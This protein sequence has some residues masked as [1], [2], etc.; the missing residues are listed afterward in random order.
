MGV[1]GRSGIGPQGYD[2]LQLLKSLI[3]QAWHGLSDPGLE[4]ARRVRLDFM[5]L[6]GLDR[7]VPDETTFCG[8]RGLLTQRGIWQKI[9]REINHQLE[10][11]GVQV[12]PSKGAVLDAT[13][14]ASA[15]RP[16]K[17]LEGMVVDR[18]EDNVRE[19]RVGGEVSLSADP[20]A[21]WLKKGKK[22]YFG[23]KGFVVTDSVDGAIHEVH[24][25][26]AHV[27]EVRTMEASMEAL[28]GDRK[29]HRLYG[30]KGYAS[31]ENR[32]VLKAK[33][34]RDGI[35]HKAHKNKP[36]THWQKLA[37][38]LMSKTR[39]IV[40]QAFGTLKRRFGFVRASYM[41]R[42][43]VEAQLIAKAIAFNLLKASR[44]LASQQETCAFS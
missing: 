41:T 9:L 3:V 4:E 33:K 43:K 7:E 32:Q 1:L 42:E 37:N 39:Y 21:R 20:D 31:Q 40:E 29:P 30:D 35:R 36:L 34:I 12:S 8:F 23:D 44:R 16:Q 26:S 24:V 17:K 15:G 10:K 22:S 11:Q 6:T 18:E 5:V 19:V 2:P 28:T 38:R 27:S 13:M 14:I 25:S